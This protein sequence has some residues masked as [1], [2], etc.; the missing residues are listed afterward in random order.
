MSVMLTTTDNPFDPHTQWREWYAW[1]L[2]AGYNTPGLLAR[3]VEEMAGEDDPDEETIEAAIERIVALNASGVHRKVTQTEDEDDGESMT[4][5][6][7]E[8]LEAE[9]E[10][11]DEP[12]D[13]IEDDEEE[14]AKRTRSRVISL[15]R[16]PPESIDPDEPDEREWDEI[17]A[18]MRAEGIDLDELGEPRSVLDRERLHHY[19]T[20]G[21]GVARWLKSRHPGTTLH[22]LLMKH[23]ISSR[24]AWEMANKWVHE[25]TG[26]WL[27][28]DVHR[29]T[30][31]SPPRGKRIG[32]G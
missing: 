5:D 26:Q 4:T 21:K 28:S 14:D 31:G 12:E 25:V 20:R 22:R 11:E 10:A 15:L 6:E 2:R 3:M 7:D 27:G 16:R 23:G 19:W 13:L 30:H 29:V 8:D 32:P 24:R 18:E 1:D 17:L 9:G